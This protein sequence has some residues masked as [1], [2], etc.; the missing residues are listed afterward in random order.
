MME[1]ANKSHLHKND[2]NRTVFIDTLD[3]KTTQFNLK[4]EEVKSLMSNG[5]IFTEKYFDWKNNDPVYKNIP[6]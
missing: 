2:W 6:V 3:I 5:K 1:M 4:P